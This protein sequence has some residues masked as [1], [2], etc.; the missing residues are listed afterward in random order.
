[1]VSPLEFDRLQQSTRC[2]TDEIFDLYG[3][4]FPSDDLLADS[5]YSKTTSDS[6]S[7]FLAGTEM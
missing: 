3:P 2:F 4:A 7:F 6:D 1:M 5:T